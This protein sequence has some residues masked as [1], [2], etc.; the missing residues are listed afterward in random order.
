MTSY[1]HEFMKYWGDQQ[2]VYTPCSLPDLLQHVRG[3][4]FPF[5]MQGEGGVSQVR[6]RPCL[7]FTAEVRLVSTFFPQIKIAVRRQPTGRL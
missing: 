5:S 7:M 2:G 1:Q 4:R 3:T 6:L